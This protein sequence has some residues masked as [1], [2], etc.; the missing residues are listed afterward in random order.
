MDIAGQPVEPGDDE[1]ALVPRSFSTLA[2]SMVSRRR[3]P[4]KADKRAVQLATASTMPSTPTLP[5]YLLNPYQAHRVFRSKSLKDLFC[6]EF[7]MPLPNSAY[8]D[9]CG[10][11]FI[12]MP[13]CPLIQRVAF[14]CGQMK[15]MQKP[16]SPRD[17]RTR[18]RCYLSRSELGMLL[19][20]CT[21][22]GSCYVALQKC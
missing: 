16:F 13:T 5:H 12:E 15:L 1:T 17:A 21:Y 7:W 18:A 10:R 11:E 3:A 14:G 9:S 2:Y 6:S 22:S 8:S 19:P 4:A 20:H